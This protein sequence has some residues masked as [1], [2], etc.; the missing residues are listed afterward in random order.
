MLDTLT[1]S[2]SARAALDEAAASYHKNLDLAAPYLLSRGVTHEAA[3]K[4]QLGVVS[5]P[6]PGHERFTGMLCLPY[7]TPAGVV[8]LKMRCIQSHDCKAEGHGKYDGPSSPARLYNV[9]ALHKRNDTIAICEGEMDTLTVDAI[10][11]VPAVGTPGTTWLEHFPRCFSDF[12][13]V[14]V[15]ADNDQHSNGDNPGL[16]HAKKVAASITG[17]QIVLPPPGMDV[18]EWVA[19]E[20]PDPVRKAMGVV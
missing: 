20:G 7:R 11:G 16:K 8:K 12:E 4:F 13:H 3:L 14:Y 9:M 1:V 5:E 17:A 10:V 19:A 2:S 6:M 15:I 18:G